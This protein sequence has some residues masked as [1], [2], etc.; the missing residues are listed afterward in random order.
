[1]LNILLVTEKKKILNEYRLRLGVVAMFALGA[2]VFS[3]LVLLVPSYLL[4][5]SKNIAAQKD[6]E[7]LQAKDNFG[8][9]WKGINKKIIDTNKRIELFLKTDTSGVV[10]LPSEAV[11][12]ILSVKGNAIRIVSFTYDASDGQERIVVVGTAIDRD[13]LAKFVEDLKKDPV[14]TSVTLPISSYVKSTNIDFS[15]VIER[16]S[17]T[18]MKK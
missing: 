2:L 11:K 4:A 15:I 13:K 7:V 16:K 3:S 10:L 17:K 5:V 8:E 9:Q 1:M 18:Q 6:L 14:F 12:K